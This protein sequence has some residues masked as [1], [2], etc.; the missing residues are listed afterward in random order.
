MSDNG[1]YIQMFSIHGLLRSRDMEM[2]RDS[3]TG[4]QIKYVVE[5]AKHLG[6]HKKVDRVDLFTRLID[7]NSV[8]DDYAVPIERIS[9][10]VRIVR[11]RARGRKYIRKEMLWPHLDEFVDQTIKFTKQEKLS[12]DVVHG[13]YADG[14]YVAMQLSEIWDIP[15]VF[16]GHS[17]GRPKLQKLLGEGMKESEIDRIFKIEQR[18][19]VEEDVLKS[20]DLVITSTNQEIERQYGMYKNGRLPEFQVIPPGLD[21]DKFYPY[22]HDLLEET[23]REESSRFASASVQ[24]ELNRFLKNPDKPLILALCRADKRKNINGLIRAYGEDRELQSIANLAIFAGLRKEVAGL[25]DSE[26]DVLTEMLLLMDNYNLY[27]KM[28]IPKSINFEHEVPELFRIAARKRGVFVNPALT[29]PFGLTLIEAASSGLPLAA[30]DDGGPQDI[31]QNCKSGILFK[32]TDTRQMS[33]AIKEILTNEETW[34]E[35]SK[36]GIINV[37]EHYTWEA[38]ASAYIKEILRVTQSQT[39]PGKVQNISHQPIG[40]RLSRLRSFIITDIDNTLTGPENQDLPELIELLKKNRDFI[41]FGIATGRHLDSA[42]EHL[43]KHGVPVPD[44]MITSVGAEIYYSAKLIRDQGWDSHLA[45]KWDREKVVR[46][47]KKFDFLEYQSD[48]KTQRKYK[49][50]YDMA[51]GKDRLAKIHDT[52]TRNRIPYNLIYSHGE[53]LDILPR[54]AS[55]G[56]ALRYLNYKW[57]IPL[58]NFLVC[59]DSGNDE[60]MLKSR[61][62]SVVVGNYSPE[63]EKLKK[64][65]SVYFA[66][67]KYAGAILE[68]IDKLD[69]LE[70]A[71]REKSAK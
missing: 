70:K 14:G 37:R 24:E 17:L 7:D 58:E 54:R 12:P 1:L 36:N 16:T 3:D 10:N 6:K 30:T 34:K 48:E 69:F 64:D 18:I 33:R 42:L 9:D 5:L 45:R 4:G 67:R 29:E 53:Y 60:E 55:K 32:A 19:G 21:V 11:I 27:G 43:E 66:Q 44:L 25:T 59:G 51:P 50:S 38:H 46:L 22:Y 52:L 61:A 49:V 47:L 57:N 31:N 41:G 39:D 65:R 23:G 56:K 20:A 63:L 68:A 62:Q 26:R 71:R 35:F 8:S 15:F 40:K 28:A 2:G 13:H